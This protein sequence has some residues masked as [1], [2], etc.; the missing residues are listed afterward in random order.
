MNFQ[1][2]KDQLPISTSRIFL[3]GKRNVPE[4]DKVKLTHLGVLLATELPHVIF[5]SGNAE[6]SDALFSEG[7]CRAD[8][9]RFEAILPYENHR[10]KNLN[11]YSQTYSMDQVDLAA[12]DDLVY[13]TKSNKANSNL[14]NRYM[15]GHKDRNGMKAAYLFRDTMAIIGSKSLPLD[16]VSFAFFYIDPSDPLGGGTGHTM[17]VCQ[18]NNIPFLTQEIWMSWV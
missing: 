11:P 4:Q 1:T 13:Y 12:D 5:R 17:K 18:E 9:S 6:G 8:P 3:G 16:P 10:K 14:V 15:D 2:F 7:V